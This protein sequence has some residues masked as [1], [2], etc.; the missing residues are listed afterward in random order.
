MLFSPKIMSTSFVSISTYCLTSGSSVHGISQARILEWIAIPI[1]RGSSSHPEIEPKS[2]ALT[3]RFLPLSYQ[4]CPYIGT[5]EEIDIT[6]TDTGVDR[7][8]Q[9]ISAAHSL[10]PSGRWWWEACPPLQLATTPL[11]P[12]H[13]RQ[14][15]KVVTDKDPEP[16]GLPSS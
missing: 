1:S 5:D 4:R 10:Q 13:D 2:P 7:D 6:G 12:Q 3:G 9:A 16:K 14:I 15:Y 11:S 8:T